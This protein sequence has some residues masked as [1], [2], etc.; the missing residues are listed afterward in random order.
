MQ[1]YTGILVIMILSLFSS[2]ASAG[3]P[4]VKPDWSKST[5]H[6]VRLSSARV[7]YTLP[8]NTSPDFNFTS[9]AEQ[10]DSYNLYNGDIYGD[11]N[12]FALTNAYWDYKSSG[13]FWQNM[14]ATLN[15]RITV[16]RISPTASEEMVALSTLPG[17]LESM[18]RQSYEIDDGKAQSE[19]GMN[20][21]KSYE[22]VKYQNEWVKFELVRHN[23]AYDTYA[24]AT[25][26][27]DSHYLIVFFKLMP[28]VDEDKG[29][30]Y[31]TCLNDIEKVMGSFKIHPQERPQ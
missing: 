21:P 11:Y 9:N 24:Y 12:S 30:W 6:N 22:Q 27:S 25:P 17:I 18:L 26:V 29:N 20:L 2:K 15:V 14:Y 19:S 7:V 23:H 1:K 31:R 3:A 16:N 5:T 10:P 4:P 8:G 28:A 13:L